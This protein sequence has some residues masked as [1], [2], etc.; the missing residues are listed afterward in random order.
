MSHEKQPK[1]IF[2][3]LNVVLEFKMLHE[4]HDAENRRLL[5]ILSSLEGERTPQPPA[6]AEWLL[7]LL[8]NA[9]QRE[10]I[11]GDFEERFHDDLA[12]GRGLNRARWLYRARAF[13]SMLPMMWQAIKRVGLVSLM[14]NALRSLPS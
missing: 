14:V 7:T 10:A 5:L 1:H 2:Y 9:E 3:D 8:S 4:C 6:L 12:K 13:H 11:L